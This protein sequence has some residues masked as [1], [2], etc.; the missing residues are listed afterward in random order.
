MKTPR[1][2]SAVYQILTLSFIGLFPLCLTAQETEPNNSPGQANLF[3]VNSSLTA[4]INAVGD[5][6][7]FALTLPEEGI[8]KVRSAGVDINDYY[9]TL[10]DSDGTSVLSN[11][12]VFPLG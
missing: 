5:E 11:K 1:L 3:P 8:L 10:Y 4:A 12:E 2:P 9:I 7:W 6:D